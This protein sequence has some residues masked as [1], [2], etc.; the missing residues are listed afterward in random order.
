MESGA[1]EAFYVY[2]SSILVYIIMLVHKG[3]DLLAAWLLA[4]L[5]YSVT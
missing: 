5:V 3:N 1:K 4:L 2:T